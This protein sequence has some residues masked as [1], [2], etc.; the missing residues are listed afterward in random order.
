M[1]ALLTLIFTLSV[2]SVFGQW[3]TP[4]FSDAEADVFLP[5]PKE[6]LYLQRYRSIFLGFGPRY[7]NTDPGTIETTFM[8]DSPSM[9]TFNSTF[10]V[11][12]GY[13]Q[14][15]MNIGYKAG[16]YRGTSHDYLL[17]VTFGKN[18]TAKF[19]YSWGWNFLTKLKGK[20]FVI[21]PAIQG[22]LGGSGFRIGKIQN[23]ASYIQINEKKYYEEELNIHLQGSSLT[24]APRIDFT[25][26]FANRWDFFLKAAYDVPAGNSNPM[27]QFSV[28][29][30]ISTDDTP[31]DS[32]VSIDNENLTITYNGEPL[33]SLPYTTG[34]LRVTFGVSY[35]W[36]R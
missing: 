31:T 12:D 16:R 24:F 18:Y 20:D 30:K 5:A 17:D 25:Y 19:A 1:K 3:S 32:F 4:M 22:I 33:V 28:P 21:R 6:S 26:I 13:A 7:L 2:L 34:G 27:L 14:F 15:A 9:D 29:D 11:K 36:N 8:D 10:E 35:L 23:N